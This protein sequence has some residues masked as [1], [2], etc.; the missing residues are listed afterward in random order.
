[1]VERASRFAIR[2]AFDWQPTAQS[3][4]IKY[5]RRI[6]EPTESTAERRSLALRITLKSSS[7]ASNSEG[8]RPPLAGKRSDTFQLTKRHHCAARKGIAALL[9][10]RTI[11]RYDI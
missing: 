5:A 7:S 4:H 1:M 11:S 9:L 10:N 3:T 6:C 8:C 2:W